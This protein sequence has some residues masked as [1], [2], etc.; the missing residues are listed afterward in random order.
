MQFSRTTKLAFP[1]VVWTPDESL[2]FLQNVKAAPVFKRGDSSSTQK[3]ILN[4]QTGRHK[5]VVYERLPSQV[6]FQL[7]NRL[8]NLIK[9]APLLKAFKT[10]QKKKLTPKALLEFRQ[11]YGIVVPHYFWIQTKNK[12]YFLILFLNYSEVL[13]KRLCSKIQSIL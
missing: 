8:P 4:Y 7:V 10:C 3:H 12:R 2:L 11:A 1:E 5:T 9:S 6:E 13:N